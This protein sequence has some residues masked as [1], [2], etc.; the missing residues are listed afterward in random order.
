MMHGSQVIGR[1]LCSQETPSPRSTN[2][3][4]SAYGAETHHGDSNR[5][6]GGCK[7]RQL[8][9]VRGNAR[10]CTPEVLLERL[11]DALEIEIVRQALHGG[12]TLAP[13]ALLH[14]DMDLALVPALFLRVSEGIYDSRRRKITSRWYSNGR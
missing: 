1:R 3:L 7:I 5:G 10:V 14:A 9:T 6:R 4:D 2:V 8:V 12:D 11:Q 13:A